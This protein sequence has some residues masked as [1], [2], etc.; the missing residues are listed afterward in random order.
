MSAIDVSGLVSGIAE[1]A[2][3]I[4]A[5]AGSVLLIYVALKAYRSVKEVLI[6]GVGGGDYDFDADASSVEDDFADTEVEQDAGDFMI[7]CSHCGSGFIAG[8]NLEGDHVRCP[9]CGKLDTDESDPDQAL[10]N[11][12]APDMAYR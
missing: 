5:V 8:E 11:S 12:M 6:G 9:E 4:A 7:E 2:G 3:P 10:E 1:Q